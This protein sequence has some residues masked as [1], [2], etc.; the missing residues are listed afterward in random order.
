M[1]RSRRYAELMSNCQLAMKGPADGS[2]LTVSSLV[3]Y[4]VRVVVSP[5]WP[6]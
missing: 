2:I 4:L 6:D 5:D 3:N 1:A